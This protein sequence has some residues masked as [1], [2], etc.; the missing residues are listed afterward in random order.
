MLHKALA[1]LPP[2]ALENIFLAHLESFPP[3]PLPFVMTSPFQ[4]KI[5]IIFLNTEGPLTRDQ[6]SAGRCFYGSFVFSSNLGV[7][8]SAGLHSLMAWRLVWAE[9]DPDSSSLPDSD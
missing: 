5:Q 4:W 9:N 1:A 6:T 8:G 3:I 2:S 7:Y